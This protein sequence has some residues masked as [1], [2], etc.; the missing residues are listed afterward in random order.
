MSG[1][2]S[3]RWRRC[4]KRKPNW[5]RIDKEYKEYKAKQDKEMSDSVN[6]DWKRKKKALP[7]EE[8]ATMKSIETQI[9]DPDVLFAHIVKYASDH[10]EGKPIGL[11]MVNRMIQANSDHHNMTTYNNNGATKE[12]KVALYG[13]IIRAIAAGWE[14]FGELPDGQADAAEKPKRKPPAKAPQVEERREPEE[15]PPSRSG[16]SPIAAAIMDEIKPHLPDTTSKAEIDKDEVE[17]AFKEAFGKLE[18]GLTKKIDS[19][20]KN[21]PPKEEI[22]LRTEDEVNKVEGF[23]HRQLPQLTRYVHSDV[24]LWL[25]GEAGAGKTHL[26]RQIAK[27]LGLEATVVSC[28]PMTSEGKLTGFNSMLKGD[29]IAGWCYKP[30]KEGGLLCLDEIDL[31]LEVICGLNALL[32]NDHYLF[33][34]GETVKRHPDFRVIAGGNTIGMGAVN[35]Y[36]ARVR[37]DAATLD[38]FATVKLEYD[39]AL[40][41]AIAL[42]QHPGSE[43]WRPVENSE[44]TIKE[45]VKYVHAVRKTATTVLISSRAIYNGVKLLKNGIPPKEVV[46]SIIFKLVTEDTRKNIEKNCGEFVGA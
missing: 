43:D 36:T 40:E 9:Q 30:Y 24:P 44:E 15:N 41:E 11:Q 20:V 8:G 29:F 35:G 28:S 18:K 22:T 38:R 10:P 19:A 13:K 6:L 2:S 33:A 4:P 23:F 46:D 31:T 45:Y 16:L 3:A 42:G 17:E 12:E 14:T 7:N 37:L 21:L 27:L 25:W 32:V 5:K 1:Y 39:P 34:N 26:F